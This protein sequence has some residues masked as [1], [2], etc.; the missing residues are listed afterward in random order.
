M[1]IK[2]VAAHVGV[3]GVCLALGGC[4]GAGGHVASA[5]DT[6]PRYDSFVGLKKQVS[7]QTTSTSFYN[8]YDS[9]NGY[10]R[11]AEPKSGF[12]EGS[13]SIDYDGAARTY[14]LHYLETENSYDPGTGKSSSAIVPKEITFGPANKKSAGNDV[15]SPFE[16]YSR[17]DGS[18]KYLDIKSLSIYK[19]A[20]A[21][22]KFPQLTYTVFVVGETTVAKSF[23][24]VSQG[25]Y[26]I[27]DIYAVAGF[28]TKPS[29]FPKTGTATYATYLTGNSF[30]GDLKIGY[31]NINELRGSATVKADFG[32]GSLSTVLALAITGRDNADVSIGTFNGVA[33][34]DVATAHFKGDLT[35]NGVAKGTFSGG[36]FGPQAAEMGYTFRVNTSTGVADGAVVGKK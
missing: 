10:T 27:H 6:A 20:R 1:K 35:E 25:R 8:H 23:S 19:P 7:L 15:N 32:A 14:S 31:G 12:G 9:A 33:P 11:D 17:D 18:G 2:I 24:G 5:S 13:I 3:A 28:E 34:I 26:T 16:K 21:N 30:E 36:L 4:G 22:S 29:D